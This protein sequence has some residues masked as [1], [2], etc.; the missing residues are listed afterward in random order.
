MGARTSSQPAGAFEHFGQKLYSSLCRLQ[1]GENLFLSP[2]S[3]ALA[4]S[5]CAVGAQHQ[6]LQQILD[7]LE[8][9]STEELVKASE[10]ILSIF[11]IVGQDQSIQAKLANRLYA[12]KTYKLEQD[13][14]KLIRTSFLADMQLE[15]FKNDNI[16]VTHEIN[17]WVE[18]QTNN[19][20]KDL[21]SP[22]DISTDT[23]LLIV[24][25]IYF[26]GT[27][28]EQFRESATDRNANFHENN[29]T[30]SK[31]ELMCQKETFAYAEN[32]SLGVQIVH[33][34]YKSSSE[35]VRFVFTIIL[36]KKGVSLSDVENKFASKP[37]LLHNVLNNQNATPRELLLYV[38]KFK[39]ETSFEYGSVLAQLGM[40]DA[41]DE[42]EADFTGIVGKLHGQSRL[43]IDKVIHRA[44]ID[45]NEQG[46]EAAAAT[47]VR[48]VLTCAS[49]R[50]PQPILFRADRPF[51]FYIRE[52][53]QN[54]TLFAGKFLTAAK[55]SS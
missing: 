21:L 23:R 1:T 15:D 26:K 22:S 46:T 30:I 40:R 3:I 8:F 42:N 14:L 44:L 9:S 29:G 13:Y 7:T 4:M 51:L 43:F 48:V 45:V 39:M 41:F 31:V 35:N 24:N 38:P 25:C 49:R 34:P 55:L 5:M 53:R 2:A 50:E 16:K 20:I 12:Q 32:S 19:L 18:Q 10:D 47:I 37:S 28:K 6:T 11:S 36:P 27:W 52:V 54:L 33:L 17:A